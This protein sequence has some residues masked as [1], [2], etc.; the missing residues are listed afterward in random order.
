MEFVFI[1]PDYMNGISKLKD[2]HNV[3]KLGTK[4]YKQL[5][6]YAA[7]FDCAIIP[8]QRGEI[9]KSTSPVKLFEYMAMGLPTVC[10]ADLRECEG[11]EHV[12]ISKDYEEFES[13]LDK[14]IELRKDPLVRTAL[15][16]QAK[17]NTWKARAKAINEAFLRIERTN[18][19]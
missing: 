16:E 5:P 12:L 4:P 14:A 19:E 18:V 6:G 2:G 1:G 13:N 3:H 15:I 10:T 8:F 7:H 11:Y 17:Q 9:A